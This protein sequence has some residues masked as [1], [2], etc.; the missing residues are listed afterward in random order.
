MTRKASSAVARA[1]AVMAAGVVAVALSPSAGVRAQG[2]LEMLPVQ[3]NVYMLAGAGA[4]ITVQIGDDGLLLVDTGDAGHAEAVLSEIR[5]MSD[6]PIRY[7]V[8]T[9]LDEDHTGGNP[10]IALAGESYRSG[11]RITADPGASVI[12]HENVYFAM[13]LPVN[14]QS[15]RPFEA[16]PTS[17]FVTNLKT[18]YFNGEGIELRHKPNAHTDGD[19]MVFFRRSDAISAGDLFRTD[20]YPVIDVARGGTLQGILDG[21][22]EIIDMTI[23]EINQM[24]GTRV[25]P[26]H[27]HFGNESDVVEYRDMATIVRD[28]VR[29]MKAAGFTL[30]QVRDARP[31]LEYDAL[32]GSDTGP[33]TTEMFLE[34]VYNEVGQ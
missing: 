11:G 30:A 28:R 8:S 14:G 7:I 2:E 21:L 23:P 4:N 6:L 16:W 13:S 31:T 22:N 29:D 15:P 9:N 18:L 26:G 27:G 24:R 5:A 12:A 3:G 10:V 1:A 25:I 33:W 32:Y 34:A 17:T 19:V 20:L